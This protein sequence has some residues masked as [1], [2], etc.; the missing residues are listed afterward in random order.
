MKLV[1]QV[2]KIS[3]ISIIL[4][5]IMG[6]LFIAFPEQIITY[7]SLAIG[8]SLI[9]IGLAGVIGFFFDKS[10]GF[11]LALGIISAIV[12]IIVCVRYKEIITLIVIILGILIIASAVFNFFTSIKI[13]ASSLVF[14]WV[15]LA[16]SIVTGIFGAIAITKSGALTIAIVQ[17]IGAT[18]IVYAVLDLIS[19]IQVRKVV[20]QIE[21]QVQSAGDIQT[22]GTIV[23]EADE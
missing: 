11:T 23:E 5:V 22:E 3:I 10:S 20:K 9:L 16:L 14:G 13:I 18:L 4:S 21:N 17:F 12:G 7:V 6:I 1:A 8:V 15:T 2:K 19:F